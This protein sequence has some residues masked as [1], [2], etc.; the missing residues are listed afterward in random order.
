MTRSSRA[1]QAA[2]N[3]AKQERDLMA[4]RH[5]QE[6]GLCGRVCTCRDRPALLRVQSLLPLLPLMRHAAFLSCRLLLVM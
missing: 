3:E 6:V 5:N 2:L 1:T 4:Q